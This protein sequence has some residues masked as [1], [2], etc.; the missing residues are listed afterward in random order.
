MLIS[1]SSTAAFAGVSCT[2]LAVLLGGVLA[3]CADSC[4]FEAG[5]RSS[6]GGPVQLGPPPNRLNPAR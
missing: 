1:S 6:R 4:T 2:A 5:W 3:S